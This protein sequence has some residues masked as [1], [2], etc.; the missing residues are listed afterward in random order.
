MEDDTLR[1]RPLRIFDV[2]FV[3]DRL[4]NSA[5]LKSNGHGAPTTLSRFLFWW[6][7]KKTYGALFGIQVDSA[8]IGF[9]GLYDLKPD[10]SSE[11]TLAIFDEDF[12]RLG[13]GTRVFTLLSQNL[14]RFSSI[15]RIIVKVQMDNHASLSFWGKL[16]FIEISRQNNVATMSVALKAAEVS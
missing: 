13:H 3:H 8:C 1:L 5:M 7:L 4:R 2:P 15:R 10:E 9:V 11:M 14:K 6:R 16:G 12:R